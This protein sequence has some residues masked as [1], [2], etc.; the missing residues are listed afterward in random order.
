MA[1]SVL[2]GI[3]GTDVLHSS[4]STFVRGRGHLGR[5]RVPVRARPVR[6]A[7]ARA[8]YHRCQ[9]F[10]THARGRDAPSAA[11]N[12]APVAVRAHD[13]STWVAL[14]RLWCPCAS[15]NSGWRRANE[16][17]SRS[18]G[19]PRPRP[20]RGGANVGPRSECRRGWAAAPRA[21]AAVGGRAVG[22]PNAL[23]PQRAPAAG[24]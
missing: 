23:L 19:R 6:D 15:P 2:F 12:D 22:I 16:L 21:A 10:P 18:P 1:V 8:S 24:S 13:A 5:Q 20:R 17:G 14:E 4:H 3:R 7:C 11:P 9:R